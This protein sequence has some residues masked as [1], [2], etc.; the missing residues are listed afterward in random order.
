MR[1]LWPTG[2]CCAKKKVEAADS[3]EMAVS[4]S[5]IRVRNAIK[6]KGENRNLSTVPKF[7]LLE[8]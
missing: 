6:Q 2:G 7:R 5:I 4:A 1:R 3:P 8:K